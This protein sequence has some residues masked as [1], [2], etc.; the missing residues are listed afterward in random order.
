MTNGDQMAGNAGDFPFLAPGTRLGA[1][2]QNSGIWGRRRLLR[3]VVFGEFNTQKLIP[4]D[5][6]EKI[7]MRRRERQS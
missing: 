1:F 6:A 5:L 3:L 4:R 2:S 7:F